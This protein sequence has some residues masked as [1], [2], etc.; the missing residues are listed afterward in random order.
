MMQAVFCSQMYSEV[1]DGELVT[2]QATCGR[3]RGFCCKPKLRPAAGPGSTLVEDFRLTLRLCAQLL[4]VA[5]NDGKKKKTRFSN[6]SDS[7]LS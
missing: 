6:S 4:T 5:F 2:A 3:T 1:S 7:H